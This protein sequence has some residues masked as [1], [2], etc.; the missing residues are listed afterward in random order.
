M[1]LVVVVHLF[2]TLESRAGA[3]GR[4][5]PL[6]SATEP[7]WG[8]GGT[9]VEL[10]FVLSGFLLF[11]PYASAMFANSAVPSTRNFYVRRALRILPAY[12]LALL[13]L[14]AY[15]WQHFLR[16]SHPEGTYPTYD[17]VLHLGLLHNWSNATAQS[18]NAVF[19]SMAVES[20][21]YV[22][23]PVLGLILVGAAGRGNGRVLW[24][25]GALVLLAAPLLG[26]LRILLARVTPEFT[27]HM[28]A[29]DLV[30]Y[31]TFFGTGMLC[32][33]WYVQW[34]ERSRNGRQSSFDEL[35]LRWTPWLAGLALLA[36]LTLRIRLWST[37]AEW[38][39]STDFLWMAYFPLLTL[40]YGALLLSALRV[41]SPA[42][43][44][45]KSR[46]MRFLGI[47]SYSVYIWH[48]PLYRAF[49]GPIGDRLSYR[50]EPLAIASYAVL[51]V[52]IIIPFAYLSYRFV[53][54]PFIAWRRASH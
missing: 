7:L 28:S 44:V 48:W 3:T 51:A 19:W 16:V 35:V 32:S 18:I 33:C 30:G 38:V 10:F 31:L 2:V 27:T 49:V 54:K 50:S 12:W 39:L 45:F 34:R 37:D 1:L 23:L 46:V 17:V 42:A 21:F 41:G 4:N 6:T 52:A 13:I 20:Q 47:I 8:F 14:V 43:Q 36:V 53:E 24:A 25:A 40:F 26:A 9:G 11:R 22:V 29:L 5:L 15:N